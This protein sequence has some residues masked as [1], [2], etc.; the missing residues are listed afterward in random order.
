MGNMGLKDYISIQ[1]TNPGQ[2]KNWCVCVYDHTH[3]CHTV[4]VCNF[5]KYLF[6]ILHVI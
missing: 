2:G 1:N 6:L 4:E 5:S 3:M